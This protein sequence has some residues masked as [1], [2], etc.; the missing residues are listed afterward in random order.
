MLNHAPVDPGAD[1]NDTLNRFIDKLSKSI[2][3]SMSSSI[4]ALFYWF[5][6]SIRREIPCSLL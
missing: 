4:T 6:G 3:E 2:E 1:F 5:M